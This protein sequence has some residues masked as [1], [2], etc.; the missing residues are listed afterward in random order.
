MIRLDK[1]AL[2]SRLAPY[3]DFLAPLTTEKE[4]RFLNDVFQSYKSGKILKILDLGCG[5]GRHSCFLA[6][7]GYK[8]TGIDLAGDM[9]KIA[10]NKCP[11]VEFKEMD[12]TN[13]KFP[14]NFFDASI[15]M[16]TT[17]G[18]I[19]S[20]DKIKTF[21]KNIYCI[22]EHLFVLDSSNYENPAKNKPLIEG[23]NIIRLPKAVI[24]SSYKRQYDKEAKL[25]RDAYVTELIEKGKK[26]VIF[27]EREELK[28]WSLEE[29]KNFLR[30]RF[31]ILKVYGDYSL[32]KTYY[33]K[34]SKRKIIIA[35]KI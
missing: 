30:P 22:T 4:C 25:R 2:Y 13:P 34:T 31:R 5:T 8:V 35:E 14:K 18:Y 17:I 26:P 20:E 24:K 7:V 32:E 9:L 16:W 12:F 28:M 23:E 6:K 21:I 29:I 10:R 1:R 33:P 27:R 3:Y 19:L 11:K 15:C